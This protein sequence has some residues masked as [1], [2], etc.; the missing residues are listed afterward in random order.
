MSGSDADPSVP[1]APGAWLQDNP[2]ETGALLVV[3]CTRA[4][5]EHLGPLGIEVTALQVDGMVVVYLSVALHEVADAEPFLV[6]PTALCPY[7]GQGREL[8]AAW[9]D[10]PV[11]RAQ[12]VEVG[13]GQLLGIKDYPGIPDWRQPAQ[14]ALTLTEGQD[15]SLDHWRRAAT[16]ALERA[17]QTSRLIGASGT[18]QTPKIGRNDACPC[19][20]GLKFKRCCGA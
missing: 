10:M 1:E 11:P 4:D 20:S 12:F 13:S 3:A 18:A 7:E 15:V 5:F 2:R 14:D 9:A 8:L 16:H 19:G 6:L 17:H